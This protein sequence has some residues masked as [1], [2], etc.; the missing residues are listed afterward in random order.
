[1]V[2]THLD[3]ALSRVEGRVELVG[4]VPVVPGLVRH[5]DQLG[6]Q[7]PEGLLKGRLLTLELP[8]QLGLGAFPCQQVVG[9][10]L[11]RSLHGFQLALVKGL[12]LGTDTR[13]RHRPSLRETRPNSLMGDVRHKAVC[14]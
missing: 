1:M 8:P 2:D 10:Q 9:G 6:P 14:L 12:S 7:L 13:V 5:P 4:L 11:L 3:A